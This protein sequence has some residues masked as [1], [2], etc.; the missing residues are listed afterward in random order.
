MGTC[1]ST[2]SGSGQRML[3]QDTPRS[4]NPTG[5]SP[6]EAEKHNAEAIRVAEQVTPIK[7][8][9]IFAAF[10]LGVWLTAEGFYEAGRITSDKWQTTPPS[11]LRQAAF[12][13]N[14][15]W[16]ASDVCL[17]EPRTNFPLQ[18]PVGDCTAYE[19]DFADP[20]RAHSIVAG[21][22]VEGS[23][24]K[25]AL[26]MW[27]NAVHLFGALTS[28]LTLVICV[29]LNGATM[30]TPFKKAVMANLAAL[31]YSMLVTGC[32]MFFNRDDADRGYPSVTLY[33]S[34]SPYAV[35]G[36]NVNFWH[37]LARLGF[38]TAFACS[39]ITMVT[40]ATLFRFSFTR[41]EVA[42]GFHALSVVG[43]SV[44][45]VICFVR[46][47]TI[48]YPSYLWA[49]QFHDLFMLSVYPALDLP[50][51]AALLWA[52]R[53]QRPYDWDQHRGFALW[54]YF[55]INNV[56][57]LTYFVTSDKGP[58]FAAVTP[59]LWRCFFVVC[60]LAPW[61]YYLY[62]PL[63]LRLWKLYKHQIVPAA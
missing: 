55:I 21:H 14:R 16:F 23:P 37:D 5:T 2:R 47:F 45:L 60:I 61:V 63:L 50:L 11:R 54:T 41:P 19:A 30:V 48:P 31:P 42:L 40:H 26:R 4:D 28:L 57:I 17:T 10:V 44:A 1:G 33:P 6:G 39:F 49:G 25:V 32:L 38:F 52:W 9:I 51:I 46:L 58:V 35:T 62:V 13:N 3:Q 18:E 8:F 53:G 22:S 36:G 20:G 34:S 29:L 15:K 43:W 7:G 27:S 12:G 24:G 59:V 56:A